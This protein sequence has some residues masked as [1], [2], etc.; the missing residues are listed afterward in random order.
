[1]RQKVT[2]GEGQDFILVSRSSGSPARMD[3]EDWSLTIAQHINTLKGSVVKDTYI[4]R[5]EFS[6]EL[7]TDTTW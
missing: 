3:H 5:T 2:Q 6:D 1:M 4:K 7:S